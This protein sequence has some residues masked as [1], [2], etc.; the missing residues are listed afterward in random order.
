[1]IRS[2]VPAR[3]GQRLALTLA[4]SAGLC[5]AAQAGEPPGKSER[6][7]AIG[8]LAHDRGPASDHHEDGVDL[9]LEL[10]FAPLDFVGSP[11][12]HLGIMANFV[13]DTSV[14][15]AGLN[16]RLRESPQWFVDAFLSLAVHDGP[17]HKDPVGCT[18]FSDCGFGTRFL[19]RFG[20]EI[21]YR[22][23]PA[24]SVSL[25]FDHLSHKWIVGGENEGL[26]HT[27]LRYL[28]PF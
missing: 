13:G 25:F 24:A 7:L 15:Y 27:G 16:L 17:L 3:I 22:I 26:D 19:P 4:M 9:N 18:Q 1:M 6:T 23:S 20:L 11:R 28:R 21:A 14:A 8:V 12:P 2:I 5:A 10:Q